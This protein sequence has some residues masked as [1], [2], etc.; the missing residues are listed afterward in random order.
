MLT[1]AVLVFRWPLFDLIMAPKCNRND[2]G[3]SGMPERS[4]TVF[5][6][7]EKQNVLNLIRKGNMLNW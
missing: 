7:S 1:V 6:L 5:P 2:A 3:R 4:Y